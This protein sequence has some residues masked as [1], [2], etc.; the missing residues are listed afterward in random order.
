MRVYFMGAAEEVTGSM[1]LIEVNGKRI[2]LDCG[3]FQ[4]RRD[5]SNRL[6]RTLP[7]APENID[8]MVLSHAHI[9]HSGSI[10]TLCR[11][12][13]G[14]IFTTPATR[15]LCAV[16]LN[17]SAHIQEKDAEFYN[18]KIA[19]HE[20][21][22]IQP[23][24]TFADVEKSLKQFITVG[25]DRPFP[26]A[27]GVTMTFVDA[28][29]VLGSASVILDIVENGEKRRLVYSGDI[30]RKNLP[31]LKDP[32]L[33]EGADFMI[34]ESTYGDRDH[35]PIEVADGKL[36]EAV[37]AIYQ[38]KGKLIIPSFALERAQEIIYS[39]HKLLKQDRIP[40]IPVF[41]DSPLT[42][43][44]TE[45]FKLHKE[46]FDEE[47]LSLFNNHEDPFDF[48]SLEQSRTKEDSQALNNLDGPMVIVSASGMCEAGRVLH[49][50]RNNISDPNNMVLIVGF[51]AKN[52]LGR[53]IV[54]RQSSVRIFGLEHDLEAEVRVINAYSAHAGKDGLDA[55]A[56]ASKDSL[57][58]LFLVHGETDQSHAMAKRL[59]GKGIVS[60][61]VPKRGEF[62][63][64]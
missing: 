19:Q 47:M 41:I 20:D 33:I 44:V 26:L 5:E 52:T 29:H 37:N 38:R 46:C 35:D 63:D 1:H 51:Q 55:F 14:N 27:D 9:D 32:T 8:V 3:M 30:G 60:A 17:D 39:L 13:D 56:L 42:L 61:T 28:G 12:Y 21:Q 59:E 31:I 23:I 18:K 11:G 54:E 53:K 49:H 48:P 43:K 57:K 22:F 45:I 7:F 10:P 25:Y 36:A 64:L 16:M 34:E 2:L 50:L 58:R 15:D 24:Y 4:G 40:P 6:N 62:F